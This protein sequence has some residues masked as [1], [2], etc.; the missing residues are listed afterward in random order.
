[1]IAPATGLQHFYLR[2]TASSRSSTYFNFIVDSH[3][4]YMFPAKCTFLDPGQRFTR[5]EAVMLAG[6]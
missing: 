5:G 4:F 2:V 3:T 6:I 1:M